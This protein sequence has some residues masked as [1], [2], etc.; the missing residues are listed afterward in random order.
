MEETLEEDH[1]C[2]SHGERAK[3]V[4]M[5]GKVILESSIVTDKRRVFSCSFCKREFSTS[6]AL[7]GHQNAHKQER[8][9][10]KRQQGLDISGF[11]HPE[12]HYNYI[13]Y[14]GIPPV[15]FYGSFNRSV[16][17]KMDSF[18]HKPSSPWMPP[19]P[20]PVGFRLGNGGGWLKPNMVSPQSDFENR[21]RREDFHMHG[22]GVFGASNSN[23]DGARGG[24]H[25]ENDRSDVPNL[26]LSLKL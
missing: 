21:M 10:A 12:L 3:K 19:P 16:G 20:P 11:G 26:D 23:G 9:M 5:K 8:A 2:P 14:S 7:G 6:Q 18:I 25:K 4:K 24:G 22:G 1:Q 15:P 13:P 17:V